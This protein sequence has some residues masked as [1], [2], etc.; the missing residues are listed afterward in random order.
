M[1]DHLMIPSATSPLR[2]AVCWR[3]SWQHPTDDP[4]EGRTAYL[5]TRNG[6][7][8]SVTCGGASTERKPR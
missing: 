5:R 3:P 6:A 4:L 8:R 7:A 2:C 1:T